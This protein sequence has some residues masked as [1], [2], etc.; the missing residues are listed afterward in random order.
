MIIIN[1]LARYAL[2]TV[3]IVGMLACGSVDDTETQIQSGSVA[4][5]HQ[6]QQSTSNQEVNSPV[7]NS[8]ETSDYALELANNLATTWISTYQPKQNAWSW[9]S[10]VFMMGLLDLYEITG[11]ESYYQYAKAW[12]DYYLDNGYFVTS[13]DTSIPGH[14]ALRIYKKEGDQRYLDVAN[15]IWH[16]ISKEAGRTSEGGLNHLGILSGNQIWVDSLFMIGPFLMDYAELTGNSAPYDEYAL[17]LSVFRKNLR[18]ESDGLYLHMYDDTKKQTTPSE[19]LY[20]GRG[21]GWAFVAY[22]L[23]KN[24]LPLKNLTELPNLQSDRDA[25]LTALSNSPTV[26]GRFHTVVNST[27]TYLETSAGLLYSYGLYLDMLNQG[28]VDVN[29]QILAE[30]WI[31]GAVN[32]ST[33]DALGNTLLLGTSYGTS[34]GDITYY[35]NVLKGENVAYGIGL[36]LLSTTAREKVG[37]LQAINAPTSPPTE[38]FVQPPIPCV[39]VDCGKFYL[40]RGNFEAGLDNFSLDATD[41]ESQFYTGTISL[42]RL[43]FDGFYEIDRLYQKDITTEQ[44]LEWV[45]S[46]AFIAARKISDS[47][48]KIDP[49]SNFSTTLER[50]VIIESGGHNAIG[51]RE[52][53][54][55]EAK[56]FEGLGNLIYGVGLV[57]GSDPTLMEMPSIDTWSTLSKVLLTRQWKKSDGLTQG[58]DSIVKGLDTVATALALIDAETDDQ[59]DDFISSNVVRLEGTFGIPGL[60]VERDVRELLIELG[61]DKETLEKIDS[62]GDLITLIRMISSTLK[63]VNQFIKWSS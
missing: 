1:C 2:L 56:L 37:H 19:A 4:Q 29:E 12:I 45:K 27:D 22:N 30:T 33:V 23:A 39:G 6:E 57:L 41:P 10:G 5:N 55:G 43:I 42:L 34:P 60:L 47:M 18:S 25:M 48:E 20:W 58:F 62:P 13:S 31:Q 36:F 61:I 16:Y 52:Y 35:N 9:D 49:Q 59:T 26:N 44:F 38:T 3:S 14:T 17:Q 24:R 51:P 50:L 32:E 46:D 53:D 63:V 28:R 11:E 21:N 54:L 7:T 8:L 15:E 40:S